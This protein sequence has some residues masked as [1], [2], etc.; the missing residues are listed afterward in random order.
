MGEKYPQQKQKWSKKQ[1]N[2]NIFSFNYKKTF[3]EK[4]LGTQKKKKK[5]RQTFS[6]G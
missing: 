3:Q 2:L 6:F 1:R 5:L 4:F